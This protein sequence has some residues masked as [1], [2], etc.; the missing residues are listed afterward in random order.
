MNAN[1]EDKELALSIFTPRVH[2][3]SCE[4]VVL[5]KAPT[6]VS[7]H[8]FN[9]YR[10]S[11]LVA[12]SRNPQFYTFPDDVML[13]IRSFL[14]STPICYRNLQNI[15]IECYKSQLMELK[16]EDEFDLMWYCPF[17]NSDDYK[18]ATNRIMSIDK[19]LESINQNDS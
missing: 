15:W 10:M 18:W 1:Q 8:P 9:L 3:N 19:A 16:K 14:H 7:L 12:T 5:N 17:S 2:C 11:G 13:V 6:Q 4:S